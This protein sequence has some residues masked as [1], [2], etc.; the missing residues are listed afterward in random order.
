MGDDSIDTVILDI[1]MGY[2]VTLLTSSCCSRSAQYNLVP[3]RL[4]VGH[5]TG[6][7]DKTQLDLTFMS[8]TP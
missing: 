4:H 5:F 3:A 2:L 7:H 8:S 6:G 1:D